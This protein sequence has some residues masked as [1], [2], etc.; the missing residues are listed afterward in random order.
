MKVIDGTHE[1]V[2]FS[3]VDAS[4]TICINKPISGTPTTPL[5]SEITGKDIYRVDEWRSP[6]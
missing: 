2:R 6:L 3:Y 4:Y 1:N 5:E